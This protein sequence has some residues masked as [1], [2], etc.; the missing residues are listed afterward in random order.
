[1]EKL[2]FL[3]RRR[4]GMSREAY[5]EHYTGS[6]IPLGMQLTRGLEGYTVNFVEA[7]G[8]GVDAVTE[9][10]IRSAAT[11]L[12]GRRSTTPMTGRR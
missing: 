9:I 12:G 10:R 11:H 6:H 1:M 4:T 3:F 7:G 2:L 8:S 5:Y